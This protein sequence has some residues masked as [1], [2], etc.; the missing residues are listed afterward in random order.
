VISTLCDSERSSLSSQ[1]PSP[2]D[3]AITYMR[4]RSVKDI[5]KVNLHLV[6]KLHKRLRL[7][8]QWLW[9]DSS[10]RVFNPRCYQYLSHYITGRF[11]SLLRSRITK[12]DGRCQQ[13]NGARIPWALLPMMRS[14]YDQPDIVSNPVLDSGLR[15]SVFFFFFGSNGPF[16]IDS[17][18]ANS[19]GIGFLPVCIECPVDGMLGQNPLS[20]QIRF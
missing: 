17:P 9:P 11:L 18:Q 12:Y 16:I 3:D 7:E 15:S 2:K 13:I 4:W 20:T 5:W 8:K 6:R 10:W 19:V 14:R 1:L